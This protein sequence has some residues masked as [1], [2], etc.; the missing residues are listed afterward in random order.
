MSTH[1]VGFLPRA[2]LQ[3]LIDLL[4]TQGYEV[5]GPQSRE[6]AI[7]YQPLLSVTQLPAGIRDQQAP[8]RYR[9]NERGDNRYFAWSNGPQALKPF[10]FAPLEVLWRARRLPDGHMEFIQPETPSR[11]LAVLGVRA[12]DLAGLRLQDQHFLEGEY[13]D[14][15]Y[16]DRRNGL[17][18]LSVN[19]SHPADTWF[20][21]LDR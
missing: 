13:P 2:Q 4:S 3:D 9:L 16:A 12:C 17:F 8:G 6:G 21:C 15:Y 10:L 11:K 20:L 18:L 14:P 19:C 1:S 7:L 5:V